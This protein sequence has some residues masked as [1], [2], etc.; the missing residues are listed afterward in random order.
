MNKLNSRSTALL[1][2]RTLF[3]LGLI[4]LCISCFASNQ[5]DLAKREISAKNM[6]DSFV[7]TYVYKNEKIIITQNGKSLYYYDSGDE[8]YR[9]LTQI[10]KYTFSAGPALLVKSPKIIDLEFQP[11][12]EKNEDFILKVDKKNNGQLNARKS[13]ERTKTEVNFTSDNIKLSGDLYLPQKKGIYPAVVLVHGSG[14]QDRNG[15]VNLMALMAEKFSNAGIAVLTYDKRGVGKSEGNWETAGFD[16]LA[17]DVISAIKFLNARD[18]IRSDCI[19]LWGSSQ[20]GW[21][22]AEAVSLKPD[23]SFVIPVSA[24]GMG[25]S[26]GEQNIYSIE[27][28]M[29][30]RGYSQSAIDQIKNANQ[31]LY[32]LIQKKISVTQYKNILNEARRNNP[33]SW[34]LPPSYEYI[35]WEGKNEWFLALDVGFDTSRIWQ[36]YKGSILA[37]FGEKDTLTPTQRIVSNLTKRIDKSGRNSSQIKVISNGNHILMLSENGEKQDDLEAS[38]KFADGV[39][40]MMVRWVNNEIAAKKKSN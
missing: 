35:N 21:V 29:N 10:S 28:E 31:A 16:L 4:T 18:D 17:N 13:F 37:V 40:E 34:W 12:T 5:I 24:A 7:G 14:G 27:Y 1:K 11:P 38:E 36:D 3:S 39:L 26:P 30:Q 9:A 25:V 8:S 19:G 22:M 33:A 2:C 23:I 20:A 15:Y 32:D 6:F